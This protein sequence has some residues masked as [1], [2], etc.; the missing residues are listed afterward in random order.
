[1]A[2]WGQLVDYVKKNYKVAEQTDRMLQLLFPVGD[3]SQFVY[4]WHLRMQDGE[5]WIQI[6]S[7][8]GK[9]AEIDSRAV[10]EL[11]G[12]IIV[13]GAAVCDGLVVLR[14]SV[15]LADMSVEEFESPFH[16]V[17]GTADRFEHQL[18]GRDQY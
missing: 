18:T 10:L 4:V 1:M 6:E 15:P 17:M 9:L 16:R 2:S 14:H 12:D 7:P 13:G 11:T 3:R 5:E 8:V